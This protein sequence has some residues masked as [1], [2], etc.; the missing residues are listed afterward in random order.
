MKLSMKFLTHPLNPSLEGKIKTWFPPLDRGSRGVFILLIVLNLQSFA[1]EPLL[2]SAKANYDK[3][4]FTMAIEQYESILSKGLSSA[5][6][7]YNL[8]NA[9]FRN[10]QI[11][12]SVLNFEKALKTQPSHENAAF[13]LELANTKL[14]DKFEAVPEVSFSGLLRGLNKSVSHN[15][16][17]LLGIVLLVAAAGVFL[18]GKKNKNVSFIK[19]A[20]I[21]A[22]TG[23]VFTIISWKQFSSVNNYKAGIIL[24]PSANIFSEPNEGSTLLFEVHEGTKVEILS[25]SNGWINVKAPNNEI[26]W[27][28]ESTFEGI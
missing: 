7:H 14:T 3:G 8:G 15:L 12:L 23:F 1:S 9:Y 19:L 11:G 18:L 17:S 16:I 4:A 5:D 27:I 22:I 2:D 10:G 21:G 13:N 25:E 26:G 6:L 20:R 24:M 28:A